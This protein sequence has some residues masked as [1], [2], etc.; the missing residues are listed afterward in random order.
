MTLLIYFTPLVIP[1]P[2]IMEECKIN[3]YYMQM[4]LSRIRKW[5]SEMAN[6]DNYKKGGS[7]YFYYK[8]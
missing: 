3:F 2:S 4:I 1:D 5:F 7:Y 8:C 6:E